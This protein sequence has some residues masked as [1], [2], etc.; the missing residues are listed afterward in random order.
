VDNLA[1]GWKTGEK[2]K[3]KIVTAA[4]TN[5]TLGGQGTLQVYLDGE[6]K[7]EGNTYLCRT[8]EVGKIWTSEY[9]GQ[10]HNYAN[11]DVILSNI[12]YK[13]NGKVFRFT[14]L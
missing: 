14:T 9:D 6:K 7:F 11:A 2:H 3:I 8:K 13:A 10:S 5:E 12:T 1:T 4:S